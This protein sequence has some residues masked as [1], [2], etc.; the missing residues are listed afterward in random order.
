MIRFQ[1]N[2][3]SSATERCGRAG[4]STRSVLFVAL[5]VVARFASAAT[6]APAYISDLAPYQTATMSGALAPTN[7][8]D[9]V[10]D[11][12]PTTWQD[13]YGIDA[14]S[15]GGKSMTGTRLI[16]HGGGHS[17][18]ANNGVYAFEFAG[19]TRP[20][21]FQMI[22]APNGAPHTNGGNPVSV[23]TYDGLVHA[24]NGFLYRVMGASFP[25]GSAT[26]VAAKN[27]L[28]TGAWTALPK[29]PGSIATVYTMCGAYDAVSGKFFCA[30]PGIDQVAFFRT[31]ADGQGHA[32]DS[33]SSMKNVG[34]DASKWTVAYDTTRRRGVGLGGIA[35]ESSTNR[36]IYTINWDAETVST[37]NFSINLP[38]SEYMLFYDAGRDSFWA[39]GG[40]S[41]SNW[42]TIYE[43]PAGQAPNTTWTFT[44]TPLNPN[45]VV[46]A[47]SPHDA[48]TYGRFVF[49]NFSSTER[50]IGSLVGTENPAFVVKLPPAGAAQV[51]PRPPIANPPS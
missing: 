40:R 50:A 14:F 7:G 22:A 16:L 38:L 44:A 36:T 31:E 20:T 10:R 42:S 46:A 24:E 15:G 32:A 26:T 3:I 1:S 8:I 39:L 19:T 27:N 2:F 37:Q 33:W 47:G 11:V 12:M 29:F 41:A 17:D 9:T 23:H 13:D 35:G 28:S 49:L 48:G 34:R 5:I 30:N 4:G 51:G 25:T 21:G 18:S 43:I 6:D 45:P